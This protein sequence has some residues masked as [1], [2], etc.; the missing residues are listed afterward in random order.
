MPKRKDLDAICDKLNITI[1]CDRVAYNKETKLQCKDCKTEHV[2]S[3][4]NYERRTIRCCENGLQFIPRAKRRTVGGRDTQV[5]FEKVKERIA[6][7]CKERNGTC[8]NQDDYKNHHTLLTWHC[9][10]CQFEWP[11]QLNN[12]HSKGSWCTDC[13]FRKSERQCRGIIEYISSK[14]F[15]KDHPAWLDGL[16]LDGY[17]EELKIA[18][19]YNGIQHY[20]IVPGWHRPP[21]H[22]E[23]DPTALDVAM[24]TK[25]EAQQERDNR[26]TKLCAENGVTLIT[27]SYLEMKK[28]IPVVKKI[29]AKHFPEFDDKEWIE[30]DD[31]EVTDNSASLERRARIVKM[32]AGKYVLIDPEIVVQ[33]N[34][35]RVPMQCVTGHIFNYDID[36]LAR[37]RGCP[38]CA[39]NFKWTVDSI[40]EWISKVDYRVTLLSDT[41]VNS[42]TNISYKCSCSR[43]MYQTLDNIQRS[44]R[45]RGR[46]CTNKIHDCTAEEILDILETKLHEVQKSLKKILE[47]IDALNKT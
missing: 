47:M 29:I 41:Y 32:I 1:T 6:V 19:E 46:I 30:T 39:T 44:V 15:A 34:T 10:I 27:V 43:A 36:S 33:S 2:C 24:Q 13:N 8:L 17:N 23:L 18:L 25:F 28:G 22:K 20:E 11:A 26:K 5:D 7:I 31:A 4:L 35:H 38:K 45:T 40:R 14:P 16:E 37:G 12:V 9:N 21:N 3:L 42:S